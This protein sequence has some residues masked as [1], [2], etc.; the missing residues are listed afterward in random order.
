MN[1]V[2]GVECAMCGRVPD[3]GWVYQCRQDYIRKENNAPAPHS[4]S[5]DADGSDSFADKARI[6]EQLKVGEGEAVDFVRASED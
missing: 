1:R 3:C 4:A 2:R 5:S 6:A